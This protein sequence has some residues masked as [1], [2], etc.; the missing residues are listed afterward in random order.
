MSPTCTIQGVDVFVE[1]EGAHT[2]VMVHGWPDDHRLW[3]S[4]VQALKARYRCVRFT[5]PGFDL[6]KPPRA[7]AVAEM[8]GLIHAIADFGSPDAPV[9]LLLHDWG[10]MFGYEFAAVHPTRVAAVVAV[11]IGDHNSRAYLRALGTK[12]GMAIFA[13][14]CWLALAWKVGSRL[15]PALANRMTRWMAHFIGCRTA[16]ERI[17]WQMN[18]PYAMAWFGTNGG[19]KNIAKVK[20]AWPLLYIFGARKPFMFHSTQWLDEVAQRPG[21]EVHPFATGH[22][23]MVQKPVEFNACILA[24]LAAESTTTAAA[25]HQIGIC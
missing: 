25:D 12:A 1:G 3:D 7:V 20:P 2:L 10:C 19:F 11:D 18:Y 17:G 23:V 22:W 13:Y 8:T 5:L 15:S 4:T 16:P 9:T 21:S 14:Q 24:W 6:T